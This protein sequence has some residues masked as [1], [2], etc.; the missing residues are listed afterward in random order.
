MEID[1][2]DIA[3]EHFELLKLS[4]RPSVKEKLERILKELKQ[5]PKIGTGKPEQLKHKYSGFWS[6]ELTQKDRIVYK[7]DEEN[8][9]VIVHQLLGHYF[10]K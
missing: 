3:L 9:I 6:R 10:D 7:I 1:F 8:G 2:T 5:H 4:G